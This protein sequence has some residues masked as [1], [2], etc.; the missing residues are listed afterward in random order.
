MNDEV[1]STTTEVTP[2]QT[3]KYLA[4]VVPPAPLDA[5]AAPTL[6][7]VAYQDDHIAAVVKPQGMPTIKMGTHK[8]NQ[9]SASQ[10]IKYCL[11]MP[12]IPGVI[13]ASP[14]NTGSLPLTRSCQAPRGAVR[15]SQRG[16][17]LNSVSQHNPAPSRIPVP[18][19]CVT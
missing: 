7:E 4:R 16:V 10:C 12:A 3:I 8:A 19:V 14:L 13:C 5:F 6:L 9:I 17:S 18:S 2:E 15:H 1:A 11:T